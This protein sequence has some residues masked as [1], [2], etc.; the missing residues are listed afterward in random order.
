MNWI[1]ADGRSKMV[2]TEEESLRMRVPAALPEFS[3]GPTGDLA[4]DPGA[5]SMRTD[6]EEREASL[7]D[8]LPQAFLSAP[9]DM[10]AKR[11]SDEEQPED[12]TFFPL[13]PEMQEETLAARTAPKRVSPFDASEADLKPEEP[14]APSDSD[15]VP[16]VLRPGG[17]TEETGEAG[18]LEGETAGGALGKPREVTVPRGVGL[19]ALAREFY[20][21]DSPEILGLIRRANPQI[22]DIDRLEVGEVLVFPELPDDWLR[23]GAAPGG[24]VVRVPPRVG[25]RALAREV[26]GDDSPE[27]IAHIKKANPQITDVDRIA[28]GDLLRFP[29][30]TEHE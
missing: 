19:R 30:L 23:E 3:P 2:Q 7:R 8:L 13:E 25:L 9:G 4:A 5:G 16:S 17:A 18:T 11:G 6:G 24:R 20:G 12:V 10:A 15:E 1:M 14:R 21:D 28:V 22:I 29:E 26:Y 27:I